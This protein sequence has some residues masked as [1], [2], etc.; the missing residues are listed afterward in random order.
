MEHAFA[1]MLELLPA[2]VSIDL[3]RVA[4]TLSVTPTVLTVKD[5]ETFA[6]ISR[7]VLKRRCL[8]IDYWAAWRSEDLFF[9]GQAKIGHC[10]RSGR[11]AS[12]N[13]RYFPPGGRSGKVT[14]I[15]R[16]CHH[17]NDFRDVQ[18]PGRGPQG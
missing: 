10:R 8:E 5:V 18:A 1:K 9:I 14:E 13:R 16:N 12:A 17:S 3:S 7:A 15:W 6:T 2:P 4:E 11:T